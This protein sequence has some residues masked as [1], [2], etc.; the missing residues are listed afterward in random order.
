ML[1]LAR[2]TGRDIVQVNISQIKSMW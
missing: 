2:R 1:Q